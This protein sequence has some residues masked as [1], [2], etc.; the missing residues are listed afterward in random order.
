MAQAKNET[1]N[2]RK[3]NFNVKGSPLVKRARKDM[4][5]AIVQAKG[6]EADLDG[7]ADTLEVLAE[8][9][10]QRG[11]RDAERKATFAKAAVETRERAQALLQDAKV[12]AAE[13][14][15]SQAKEGVRRAEAELAIVSPKAKKK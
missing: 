14:K 3:V 4:L 15:V 9:L 12:K 10:Q 2:T 13:S 6:R 5:T 11:K 7:L 1:L 8:F